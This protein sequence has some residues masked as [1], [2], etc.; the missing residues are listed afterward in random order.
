MGTSILEELHA[1]LLT[2]T[3]LTAL[4]GQR[5]YPVNTLRKK[6][7]CELP[8]IGYEV[9]NDSPVHTMAS[10]SANPR[11]PLVSYHVWAETYAEGKAAAEQL[12]TALT[13]KTG[14]LTARTIQRAFW[15]NEY[16]ADDDEECH[17]VVDFVIWYT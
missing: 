6:Q 10:D 16:D 15:E 1:F 14:T 13:D 12:R 5:I 2:Q 11:K 8:A 3:G 7:N 17:I 9:V 4:V